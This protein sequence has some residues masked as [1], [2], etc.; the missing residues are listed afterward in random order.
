MLEKVGFTKRI[1][2]YASELEDGVIGIFGKQMGSN[3]NSGE[4]ATNDKSDRNILINSYI[5]K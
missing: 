1:D 2:I 4:A 5:S 3:P